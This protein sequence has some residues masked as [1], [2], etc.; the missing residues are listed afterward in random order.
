MGE[1]AAPVIA[2]ICIWPRNLWTRDQCLDHL[3]EAAQRILQAANEADR[4]AHWTVKPVQQPGGVLR[5]DVSVSSAFDAEWWCTKL[6][7]QPWFCE[8]RMC[9]LRPSLSWRQRRRLKPRNKRPRKGRGSLRDGLLGV[10]FNINSFS[11]VSKASALRMGVIDKHSP[12]FICLQETKRHPE[13]HKWHLKLH[14]SYKFLEVPRN[15]EV[16]GAHGLAIGV[17]AGIQ[18]TELTRSNH[19]VF[20][21][22]A[23][24]PLGKEGLVVGSVYIPAYSSKEEYIAMREKV[25]A[26]L[27]GVLN[28]I[29]LRFPRTSI[30]IGGDWNRLDV[31]LHLETLHGVDIPPSRGPSE[32][33]VRDGKAI[34]PPF[35]RCTKVHRSLLC[36]RKSFLRCTKVH[37]CL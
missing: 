15:Q 29:R 11:D 14:G 23:G 10:T 36:Q 13:T 22:L 17:R 26:D 1:M 20:S 19:F 31:G 37:R 16:L 7:G 8:R 12:L 5:L 3:Q 4:V 18:Q 32:S 33:F 28:R 25:T 27:C 2:K 30:L 35:L 24:K 21:R 34:S 6:K 9:H